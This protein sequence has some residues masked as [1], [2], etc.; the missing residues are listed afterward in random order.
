MLKEP[1]EKPIERVLQALAD[2][3]RREMVER[4]SQGP[5]TVSELARPLAMT[6]AAALQ[7]VQVL[8]RSGLVNTEKQGRVRLVKIDPAGLSV[9][10]E[11]LDER[12]SLWEKRL[13]GLSAMLQEKPKR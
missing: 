11:W 9:L 13:D 1:A 2:G 5:V 3:T 7:H 8:E 12:R 4:V 10:R 6:L